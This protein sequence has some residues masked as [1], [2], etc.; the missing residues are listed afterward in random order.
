MF[1]TRAEAREMV[2]E[3]VGSLGGSGQVEVV[4]CPPFTA[5]PT[6]AEITRGTRIQLGAQNVH[7]EDEGAFTGEISVAMLIECGC[8]YVIL[9]HS[10]RREHFLESD[11]VVNRKLRKVL[12]TSLVPILCVGESLKNREADRFQ[13]VIFRQ[14]EQDVSSLT[15]QQLSRMI[16]AYEPIWAI[17]TGRTATPQVA[18]Q[19]HH[20]IRNWLSDHYS[21]GLA[22]QVRILYGGSVKPESIGE[23]M[24]QQDIDGA[25]VGGASLSAK[26]FT[27][28]VNYEKGNR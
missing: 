10:E 11:Q 9:G 25:L 24:A 18:A 7:W 28:I 8:R 19:I 26:L 23:L 16:L 6:I 17:G 15:E 21:E 3:L 12:N 4:L 2:A 22:A 20:T 14:L 1:K 5:L 27:E 13:E